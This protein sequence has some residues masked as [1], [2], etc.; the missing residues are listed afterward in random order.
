MNHSTASLRAFSRR[1]GISDPFYLRR[2]D[3]LEKHDV[4][5]ARGFPRARKIVARGDDEAGLLAAIDAVRGAAES[6]G[7]AQSHLGKDDRVP[8]AQNEVD[9]APS[10]PVAAFDQLE[11]LV[12]QVCGGDPLG[13]VARPHFA[14]SSETPT[15]SR[16]TA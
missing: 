11:P 5:P 2:L 9:L 1:E 16:N 4:E 10:A 8:V 14:L 6:L 12:L 7:A 15:P 3:A 13:A